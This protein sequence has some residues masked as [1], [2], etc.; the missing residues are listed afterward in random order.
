[1]KYIV[2]KHFISILLLVFGCYKKEKKMRKIAINTLFIAGCVGSFCLF[3]I[4]AAN[5]DKLFLSSIK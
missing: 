2:F 5:I 3:Y 4:A 1:M